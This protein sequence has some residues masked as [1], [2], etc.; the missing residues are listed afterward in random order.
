ME[1]LESENMKLSFQSH[2]ASEMAG[3]NGVQFRSQFASDL[4][5]LASDNNSWQDNHNTAG[6]YQNNSWQDKI[7][8]DNHN[9]AGDY[10]NKRDYSYPAEKE[11]EDQ[12]R[13]FIFCHF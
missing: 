5:S 10:Q 4:T 7:T 9:T 3:D 13:L 8:A 1:I 11:E 2:F 6:D 12:V